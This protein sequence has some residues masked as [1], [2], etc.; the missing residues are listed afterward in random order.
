MRSEIASDP[1]SGIL[2]L[3]G[4]QPIVAGSLSAGGRWAVRFPRPD[5]I[6]FFALVKG[7]CWLLFDAAPEPVRVAQGDVLLMTGQHAFTL[8]SEPEVEPISAIGLFHGSARKS[9]CIGDG[10][11]CMQIGGHIRLAPLNGSLLVDVLPPLIHIRADSAGAA[12]LQ[13]LLARLVSELSTSLPGGG[14]AANN[15]TSLMFVEI[16]RIYMESADAGASG[17]LRAIGDARIAPALHLMHEDLSQTWRLDTLAAACAMSRTAFAVHFREVAGMAP[18]AWL[19]Q[20]RIRT[21]MHVLANEEAP[22]AA[23]AERLGYASESA[24]STAFKRLVGVAPGVY[25]KNA[26]VA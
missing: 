21:A 16:L 12:T 8:A 14:M 18:M 11:A 10:L 2:R 26:R 22:M 1:L 20:W 15:L 13:W 4:A 25:R 5:K 7:S 19:A 6:K 23:L 17:W 3:I 9:A 24:F